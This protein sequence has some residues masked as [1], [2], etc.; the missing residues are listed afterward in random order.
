M[1][2]WPTFNGRGWGCKKRP[3]TSTVIQTADG[4]QEFRLSRFQTPLYEF[5]IEI[6]YLSA[7][8][9]TTLMNF[10]AGQ[11]GPWTPFNFTPDGE[12]TVYVVRF[13]AD[14]I[15]VAQTMSGIYEATT[16][17]LRSVR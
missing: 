8:D 11:N 3:I 12:E 13:A 1:N 6:P 2:T 17:T 16:I 4:G 14:Q 5:D 10:F 9:Y 15:E 7:A